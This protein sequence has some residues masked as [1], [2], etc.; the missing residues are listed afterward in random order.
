MEQANSYLSLM[1]V[2]KA[3]IQ[4]FTAKLKAEILSGEVHPLGV[5]LQLKAMEDVITT[6][7][8]DKQV[9]A[10]II[11]RIDGNRTEYGTAVLEVRNKATYDYSSDSEWNDL[12][13]QI[14][15]LSERQKA[16]Q[17]FLKLVKEP[18]VVEGTGEIINPIG[19]KN[20][21][22]LVVTFKK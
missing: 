8:K 5:A 10:E 2:T 1:P 6:L 4:T 3:E 15:A 12:E 14:I 21:E 20:S 17:E 11:A 13:Q 18:I 22:S 16:R 19:V 9:Q 7:R